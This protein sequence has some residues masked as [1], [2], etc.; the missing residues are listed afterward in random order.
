MMLFRLHPRAALLA[1][2]VLSTLAL[3]ACGGSSGEAKQPTAA[4][5][6]SSNV[7]V[8]MFRFTPATFRVEAGATVSWANRD[9]ILHTVTSG[10]PGA[11][12]GRFDGQMDGAGASFNYVFAEAG[13]FPFFCSRHNAMVGEVQVAAK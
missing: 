4:A 5:S 8:E 9:Q 10:T 2:L 7:V 13:T 12:T 11:P 6:G 1:G 3:S